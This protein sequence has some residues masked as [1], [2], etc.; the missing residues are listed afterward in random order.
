M[1]RTKIEDILGPEGLL[2]QTLPRYE[3]RPQQLHMAQA[4]ERALR[5]PQVLLVEAATGTGKTLAYL[6]PALLS[7][8]RVVVST[9]TKALQEQLFHK[10]I[11][12]LT[13]H[14]PKPF[15]A[16]LLK[17]RRN[18]LCQ[19]RMDEMLLSPR[20]RGAH[21]AKHWERI[22]AWA[23]QTTTGDRAEI[24]GLPDDY[25][26]W[27]DLSVSSEGCQGSKCKH[28]EACYVTQARR[29]AQEAQ[30]IVVNHHLFFADLALREH[31]FA[32]L[33]PEYDAVIFDEAHHLED[34]ASAYFGM[35]LSNFRLSELIADIRLT[36]SRDA[37]V[38]APLDATLKQLGVCGTS[39]FTL[40]AFGRYEGRYPLAEILKGGQ[41][42]KIQ[43]AHRLLAASL[44]DVE[45]ELKRFHQ[46]VEMAE[47]LG[48][49]SAELKFE[50]DA[51]MKADDPRYTYLFEIK[52]RGVFMQ[53]APVDLA[54]IFERRLLRH[55]DT[56]IFTSATLSTNADFE[57]FKR[58]MGLAS[59]APDS[60]TPS[61]AAATAPSPE[62]GPELSP[63]A[64]PAPAPGPSGPQA[65]KAARSALASLGL[66][67]GAGAQEA[68]PKPLKLHELLLEPVFDYAQQCL[69]YIPK[70]LPAPTHRDFVDGVIQIVEYL[71]G[72]TD[73]RAFVLFTSYANMNAV[74]DALAPK[75]AQTVL[76]QGERPKRELI[77]VFKADKRSVLF[78]TS[79]F[80]EGVDV[81]GDA[82][83]LVILDKL[84]FASPGD[85]LI[86]ARMDLVESRG[87]SS[88]MELSVPHAALTL[89]QGF[90]RLIRSRHDTGIVAILDSRLA[91]KPYGRYFLK[92]LPPAPVVWTAPEV[93]RWWQERQVVDAS[94]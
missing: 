91:T 46:R 72:V 31:S 7:G 4:V 32:E 55:H 83:Q 36:L 12:F 40:M 29:A 10:D 2:S 75:L 38:D 85:P 54:E 81:E 78:A 28:Y 37:L 58:R 18:Y 6:A 49:R 27:Q 22:L 68:P 50:L 70:K 23:R 39:L 15:K 89:K 5:E 52:D 19:V 20:F 60:P 1:T 3:F 8:K 79:S 86:K 59:P 41:R 33:L 53:A 43:E 67:P 24:S 87:G 76:K 48:A 11:P 90:G 47:R 69:L 61:P 64:R 21:D 77:E 74:H 66:A 80:W 35:Q 94:G 51:M 92:T 65:A 73:G 16:V 82:L 14:W 26:T 30:V 84:P 45:R 71:I 57:F 63:V 44:T 88:F 25:A 13:K 93:K 9:G 56:L 42:D 17:G 62:L 34:V